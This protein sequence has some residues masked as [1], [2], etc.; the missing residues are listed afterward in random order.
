[1]IWAGQWIGGVHAWPGTGGTTIAA[2]VSRSGNLIDVY[3]EGGYLR[4]REVGAAGGGTGQWALSTVEP[5]V[6]LAM[7]QDLV[8]GSHDT[9]IH[10]RID[11]SGR[12]E[13]LA[14]PAGDTRVVVPR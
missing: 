5:E 11:L 3:F 12:R 6:E 10:A 9:S 8:V 7:P 2:L 4:F 14:R 13:D 1:L